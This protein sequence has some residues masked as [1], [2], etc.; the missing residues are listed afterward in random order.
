[1]C[2]T[3]VSLNVYSLQKNISDRLAIYAKSLR[4][5][6]EK[7]NN[8]GDMDTNDLFIEIS[9]AIDKRLWFL[10]AHLQT[11]FPNQDRADQI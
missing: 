3:C 11:S 8:L 10:E 4:Q 1:M 6:I 2:L 5:N 7:T 9:R